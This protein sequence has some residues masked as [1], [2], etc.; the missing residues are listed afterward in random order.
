MRMPSLCVRESQP[1]CE[2]GQV[3]VLNRTHDKMPVIW[4]QTVGKQPGLGPFD[5]L[6]KDSLEGFIVF[7]LFENRETSIRSIEYV[8]D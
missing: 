1:T 7:V 6:L 3:T 2:L 8:I 4:H 5:R